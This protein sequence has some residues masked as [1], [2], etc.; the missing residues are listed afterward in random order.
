MESE[1][2]AV[3]LLLDLRGGASL[4]VPSHFWHAVVLG[5]VA[6]TAAV[7]LTKVLATP[8]ANANP[9]RENVHIALGVFAAY[10]IVWLMTGFV[11]MGYVAD[12]S[13]IIWLFSL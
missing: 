10:F 7:L 13:P 11:P 8:P 3:D 9:F 1:R 5:L 4:V 6:N 12:S 2:T